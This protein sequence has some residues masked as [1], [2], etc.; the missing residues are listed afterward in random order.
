M[1]KKFSSKVVSTVELQMNKACTYMKCNGMESDLTQQEVEKEAN[2]LN[3]T[4]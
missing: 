1:M 2:A 3:L 4:E